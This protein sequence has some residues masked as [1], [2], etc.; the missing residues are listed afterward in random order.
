MQQLDRFSTLSSRLDEIGI[1]TFV[2]CLL[3]VELENQSKLKASDE[4]ELVDRDS[5]LGQWLEIVLKEGHIEPSQPFVGIRTGW[6]RRPMFKNS[7][8]TD[9]YC[10]CGKH[11]V[12]KSLIPTKSEFYGVLDR[13]FLPEGNKYVFPPLLD[14]QKAMQGLWRKA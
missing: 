14:C 2:Q 9:F 8:W 5:L 3:T 4:P 13:L 1:T 10:W 7:L 11:D 12:E 6:P